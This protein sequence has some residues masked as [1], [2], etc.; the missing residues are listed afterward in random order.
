MM[1]AKDLVIIYPFNKLCMVT[2]IVPSKV[3]EVQKIKK[4]WKL[5]HNIEIK[6]DFSM[7]S[8]VFV[9]SKKEYTYPDCKPIVKKIRFFKFKHRKR[10]FEQFNKF[11][12]EEVKDI[13]RNL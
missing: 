5:K 13:V 2:K 9:N 7:V 4:Y 3:E 6:R 8:I 12:S 11:A 1:K 10:F